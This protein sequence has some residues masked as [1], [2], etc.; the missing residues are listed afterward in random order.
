MLR[1]VD[2]LSYDEI[3]EVMGTSKQTV[4]NQLSHALA[5]LRDRLAH[6]L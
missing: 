3:T 2:G 5:F 6:F 1:M 4:A